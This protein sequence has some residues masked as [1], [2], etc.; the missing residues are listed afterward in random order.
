MFNKKVDKITKIITV[1]IAIYFVIYLAITL[2]I[3]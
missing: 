1:G 2:C 3:Y